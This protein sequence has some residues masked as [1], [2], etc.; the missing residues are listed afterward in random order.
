MHVKILLEVCNRSDLHLC[1]QH[2]ALVILKIRTIKVAVSNR[3][4]KNKVMNLLRFGFCRRPS[5]F[6]FCEK[7]PFLN[8]KKKNLPNKRPEVHEVL[9]F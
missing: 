3:S 5:L 7:G 6:A 8:L 9:K 2:L 1:L 4:S